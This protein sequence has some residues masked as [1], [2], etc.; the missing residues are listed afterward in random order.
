MILKRIFIKKFGG[1]QDKTIEFSSGVNVFYDVNEAEKNI[2]FIFMKAMLF[3]MPGEGVRRNGFYTEKDAQESVEKE[4]GTIWFR[5]GQKNYRLTREFG[6]ETDD[7][8]LFCEDTGK[9]LDGGNETLEKIG[10]AHV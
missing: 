5:S 8:Q 2:V 10:R 4:G 3:G 9:M 1:L 6:A 7:C